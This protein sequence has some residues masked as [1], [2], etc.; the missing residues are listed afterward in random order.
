[1]QR[2]DAGQWNTFK[3]DLEEFN[4]SMARVKLKFH[5]LDTTVEFAGRSGI[6][7]DSK[8]MGDWY[9]AINLLDTQAR[10]INVAYS[11]I[12]SMNAGSR[13]S[14]DPAD[15]DIV[16][17]QGFLSTEQVSEATVNLNALNQAPFNL[18]IAP[19]VVAGGVAVVA[20]VV[21]AIATVT[22]MS[23]KEKQIEAWIDNGQLELEKLL[24]ANPAILTKWTEYKESTQATTRG[25][26]DDLFG[27]G[28]SKSILA[29]AGGLVLLLVGGYFLMKF[30]DKKNPETT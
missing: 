13:P 5:L 20:L 9:N 30:L 12:Q 27:S 28:T 21:G 15:F 19:F 3:D 4:N 26:I 23:S 22:I 7:F 24:I 16:A 8:L 10:A 14:A 6:S 1:M 11:Y 17:K 25:A 2:L 29:G 18:G